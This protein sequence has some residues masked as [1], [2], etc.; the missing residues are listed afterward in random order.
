[1][2]RLPGQ[3][4]RRPAARRGQPPVRRGLAGAGAADRR[5]RRPTLA[6][7]GVAMANDKT[8]KA[9]PKK[10]AEARKKGQ[11][12]RSADLNGAIVL[13]VGILVLGVA[14]SAMASRM[15]SVMGEMF[16]KA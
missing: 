15:G 10:R 4:R 14:G 2:R 12:A 8:E 11:V 9:T 1:R 5:R 16:A 7:A 3:D 13:L 6:E